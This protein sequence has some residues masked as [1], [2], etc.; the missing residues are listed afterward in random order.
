MARK[1]NLD[2]VDQAIQSANL[3]E[4]SKTIISKEKKIKTIQILIEWEN[5]IKNYYGGTINSY[6]T[7]SIQEK[8]KRDGIL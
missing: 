1:E 3:R 8:M 5:K 7:M 2:Y 6:I 4:N